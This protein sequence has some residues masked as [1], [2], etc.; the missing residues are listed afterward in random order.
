[1]KNCKLDT[2]VLFIK[3]VKKNYLMKTY[4]KIWFA[5]LTFFSCTNKKNSKNT[6]I[7]SNIIIKDEKLIISNVPLDKNALNVILEYNF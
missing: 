7:E 5:I 1:M 6:S 2:K 4:F 3:F